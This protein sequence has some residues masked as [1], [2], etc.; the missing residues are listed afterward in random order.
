MTK[1]IHWY[2]VGALCGLGAIV[3]GVAELVGLGDDYG[4]WLVL[5]WI[6]L[7]VGTILRKLEE[8]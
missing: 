8:L 4:P 3:T 2:S 6:C 7:G 5:S 1:S